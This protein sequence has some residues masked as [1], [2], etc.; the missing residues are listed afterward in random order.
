MFRS[1]RSQHVGFNEPTTWRSLQKDQEIKI[2]CFDVVGLF[3]LRLG[4]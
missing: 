2:M 4:K 1:Q 3:S